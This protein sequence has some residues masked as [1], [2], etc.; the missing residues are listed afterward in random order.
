MK[1][2][3]P[4]TGQ[5]FRL[6]LK[7]AFVG[8]GAVLAASACASKPTRTTPKLSELEGKKVA[9]VEVESEPTQRQMI[10]VA[11]VNQLV[12]DGSFE[13]ISKQAI[14]QARSAPDLSPTDWQGIAKRAGADLAL[15]ARVIEFTA[16]DHEGFTRVEK[17]D[18]L[19]AAEQGESARKSKQLVRAKSIE[20]RVQ[21]E[22]SFTELANSSHDNSQS[23]TRQAVAEATETVTSDQSQGP[24][25][26]PGKMRFLEKLTNRAF[27]EF[28]DRYR[29]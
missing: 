9:L 12:R 19:L 1:P 24:I 26:L 2:S 14:D 10:E 16:Q 28:F 7:T 23:K 20:G 18:S 13:L 21:I 27:A 15:R 8:L 29:N 25:Q 3:S 17:E 22:L 11:L 6:R 5:H 4:N